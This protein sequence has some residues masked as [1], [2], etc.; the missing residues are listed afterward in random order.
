[1]KNLLLT[2][3]IILYSF[4]VLGQVHVN[5]YY[6][7]NGTYVAPH[8]RSSPNSSPY[9]NYSYPGNTNPYTGKIATGDPDAYIRNLYNKNTDIKEIKD[10]PTYKKHIM[11]SEF[12]YVSSTTLNVRS[13]PS[14][15]HPILQSLKSGN[16]VSILEIIN[17][18]WKKIKTG[19]T[20]GYVY[21]F[22]LTNITPQNNIS[23]F[24]YSDTNNYSDNFYS[25]ERKKLSYLD[26]VHTSKLNVRSGPSTQYSIITTLGYGSLVSVIEEINYEWSKISISYF[27]EYSLKTR[28]GYVCNKYIT[29][30]VARQSDSDNI[31]GLNNGKLSIWTDCSEETE[32]LVYVDDIY[33]GK[34]TSYFSAISPPNCEDKGTVEIVLKEGVHSIRA[35]GKKKY[36]GQNTFVY[37]G[38]CKFEQLKK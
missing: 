16:K 14:I 4:A 10:Y 34:I 33:H 21:S 37:A 36:W 18:S 11:N 30:N 28:V 7:S 24:P 8:M 29:S 2:I 3:S 15:D 25:S 19:S 23:N 32:I 20:I 17:S 27:D 38:K 9:D 12:E 31:Y 1:M 22:Y 5:G 13:G 6:R 26:F 35:V